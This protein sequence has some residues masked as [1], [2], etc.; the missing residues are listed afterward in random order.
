MT[1]SNTIARAQHYVALSNNHELATIK[2]LFTP[3][4]TYYSVFF[5]EYHG[6]DTIHTMMT[7]FFSR[8]ADAHWEVP[9]YR[10]IDD[11]GVEFSFIM[12]G[13]D[14]VSGERVQRHGVERIYFTPKGFIER[15]EVYKSKD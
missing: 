3:E 15:I 9:A 8:F 6:S 12:T 5:G 10:S 14:T 7:S 11:N 1:E 13:S 2:S 4:A